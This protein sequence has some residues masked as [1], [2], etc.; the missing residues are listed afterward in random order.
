MSGRDPELSSEHRLELA[1]AYRLLASRNLATRL[2]DYAGKPI[3]S[4]FA[5]MPKPMRRTMD[6]AIE[7]A[8]QEC[9][10]LA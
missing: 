10:K 1:R 2:S 4:A 6:R 7:R 5:Q 3:H 9:L 8:I